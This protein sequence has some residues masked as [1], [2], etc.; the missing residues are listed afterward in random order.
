M[1]FLELIISECVILVMM[2]YQTFCRMVLKVFAFVAGVCVG[3]L[4]G[5]GKIIEEKL[6]VIKRRIYNTVSAVC[7]ALRVY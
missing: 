7:T 2:V 6:E 5:Y 3:F 1:K 4:H